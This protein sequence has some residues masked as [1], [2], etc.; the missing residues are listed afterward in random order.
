V[1]ETKAPHSIV[2]I[3]I[4]FKDFRKAIFVETKH[5]FARW[6]TSS[7]SLATL[8]KSFASF[9]TCASK[10]PL[11]RLWQ[12]VDAAPLAAA[13]VI[14]FAIAKSRQLEFRPACVIMR[15]DNLAAQQSD[16]LFHGGAHQTLMTFNYTHTCTSA[17]RTPPPQQPPSLPALSL[18]VP[19]KH[20]CSRST[21]SMPSIH[22]RPW[23]T[24]FDSITLKDV[25]NITP[26]VVFHSRRVPCRNCYPR[27]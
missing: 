11:R 19:R 22:N 20:H 13:V 27:L 12:A 21:Q 3:I 2:I 25:R 1:I 5:I 9:S 7:L 14:K 17:L 8:F 23:P 24:T 6:K 16:P 18:R 10:F 26:H 15:N 4:R